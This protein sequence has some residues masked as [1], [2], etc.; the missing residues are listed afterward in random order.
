MLFRSVGGRP[1]VGGFAWRRESLVGADA[2]AG[3]GG[4]A[5]FGAGTVG[6]ENAGE[7]KAPAS[8]AGELSPGP[9]LV[10]GEANTCEAN[11]GELTLG[12]ART[13]GELNVD[14][15]KAGEAMQD[16]YDGEDARW[17]PTLAS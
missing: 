6:L 1:D 11:A 15:G 12:D 13:E 14:G 10:D 7:A 2:G 8:K 17:S 9:A 3:R 16:A 5:D 4:S